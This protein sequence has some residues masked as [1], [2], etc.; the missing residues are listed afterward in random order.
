MYA[1]PISGSFRFLANDRINNHCIFKDFCFVVMKKKTILEKI[2]VRRNC[3]LK[4]FVS[5]KL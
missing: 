5:L 3:K 1:T 4:E 2:I